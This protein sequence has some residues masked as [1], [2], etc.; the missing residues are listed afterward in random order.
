VEVKSP[1]FTVVTNA[2]EKAGR[3]VAWQ[4]E[5]IRAAMATVFRSPGSTRPSP[6]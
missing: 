2:G 5:Q 6:S 4:F 1:H 3:K